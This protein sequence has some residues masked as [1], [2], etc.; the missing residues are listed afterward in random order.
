MRSI[1]DEIA[2]AEEKAEQIRLDAAAQARDMTA[3][4]R[5]LAEKALQ[6]TI[7]S[8]R[9]KT[10]AELDQSRLL[11]EKAAKDAVAAFDREA[12]ELCTRAEGKIGRAVDYLVEK[13]M[14]TA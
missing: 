12:E 3:Q 11:G 5:E 10:E 2:T 6:E 9:V 14:Q 8:E 4:A 7:K 1:I 13:V